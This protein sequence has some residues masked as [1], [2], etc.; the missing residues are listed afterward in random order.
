MPHSFSLG[1]SAARR[2]QQP[3]NETYA[4]KGLLRQLHTPAGEPPALRAARRGG[5]SKFS[6]RRLDN[7]E[8]EAAHEI[9]NAARH[10]SGLVGNDI[11]DGVGDFLGR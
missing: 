9:D 7:E 8:I 3:N 6:D 4:K 1:A 11:G 2:H 5:T 10:I